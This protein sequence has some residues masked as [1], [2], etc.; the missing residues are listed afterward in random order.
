MQLAPNGPVTAVP[1][2]RG[3]NYLSFLSRLHTH[4]QPGTYLEIGTNDG[5][6]LR[7]VR[8]PSIAIDPSFLLT[9]DVL[10]DKPALHLFRMT[11]DAFFA[12]HDPAALL[13]GPVDMAFLDGMHL[14]EFL[15]RDFSHI[16]PACRRN[17]VVLM[18]DCIPTDV[19]MAA[20]DANSAERNLG[21][22]PEWWTGDVWKV[23]PALRQYRPDLVIHA[24]DAHPTGLIA[25]TNLDPANTVLAERYFE[26]VR[27]L[28]PLTLQAHGIERYVR[29]LGVI[30]TGSLRGLEDMAALFWL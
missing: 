9:N 5:A 19:H 8:C 26:V 20:R 12:R 10:G 6:S 14:W 30:S 28:G 27:A 7:P 11:S 1:D 3:E 2:H 17:S 24:F 15:L 25:V 18:H 21:I 22:H 23:V 13:G 4:L 29:E 16:E